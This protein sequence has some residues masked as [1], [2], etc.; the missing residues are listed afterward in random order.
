MAAVLVVAKVFR[1]GLHRREH[2]EAMLVSIR[3]NSMLSQ[4]RPNQTQPLW[5]P[6]VPL[7]GGSRRTEIGLPYV[8]MLDFE[9]SVS[10]ERV[11]PASRKPLITG[12]CRITLL[13]TMGRSHTAGVARKEGSGAL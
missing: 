13:A 3:N 10:A 5:G 1:T 4:R 7:W 8:Y 9:Y 12:L 2:M 6:H 11:I